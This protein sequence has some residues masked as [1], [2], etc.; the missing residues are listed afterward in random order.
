MVETKAK[1]PV[2]L[3]VKHLGEK[4]Y[5]LRKD[6]LVLQVNYELRGLVRKFI[7]TVEYAL[8]TKVGSILGRLPD[9]K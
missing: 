3:L 8:L 9:L 7:S 1:L 6:A 5:S 2:S 4:K